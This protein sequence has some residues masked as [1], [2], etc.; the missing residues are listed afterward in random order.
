MR[1]AGT[2]YQSPSRII[3]SQ[4]TEEVLNQLLAEGWEII[5]I[6]THRQAFSKVGIDSVPSC[7]AVMYIMGLPAEKQVDEQNSP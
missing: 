2:E 4:K 1:P 7:T 3:A 5:K 6:I